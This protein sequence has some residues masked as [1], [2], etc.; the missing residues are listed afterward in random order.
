MGE[1]LAQNVNNMWQVC[2]RGRLEEVIMALEAGGDPESTGGQD[3]TTCL[4]EA[5]R[6]GRKLMVA[7][8][9]S[10]PGINVNAK[11]LLGATALHY[12]CL[13][14]STLLNYEVGILNMLLSCP[15]LL[16]NEKRN[17]HPAGLYDDKQGT[18][19][20]T[21]VMLAARYGSSE[22]L[23]IMVSNAKVDLNV[24]DND[25]LTL[26]ASFD[27]FRDGNLRGIGKA[28]ILQ[29]VEEARKRRRCEHLL[30]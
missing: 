15:G 14:F 3:R 12:A 1:Q 27:G 24:V 20:E 11:D 25:G 5:V 10:V 29:I 19:G 23:R 4:M 9:L 28:R 16:Y 6:R 26:E 2:V 13:N 18:G 21:P 30:L 8:L 17:P 22:L 7:K